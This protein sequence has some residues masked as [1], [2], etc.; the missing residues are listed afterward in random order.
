[1]MLEL[2]GRGGRGW[3]SCPRGLTELVPLILQSLGA[4]SPSA[5]VR[6]IRVSGEQ[7]HGLGEAWVR[8]ELTEWGNSRPEV[9]TP[10]LSRSCPRNAQTQ[11]RT[12]HTSVDTHL[13]ARRSD[14]MRHLRGCRQNPRGQVPPLLPCG[15]LSICSYAYGILQ[16]T[17][18][19]EALCAERNRQDAQTLDCVYHNINPILQQKVLS[20]M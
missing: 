18:A 11:G 20:S 13:L 5:Q 14:G 3:G 7:N 19:G 16:R 8:T 17:E 2:Y 4:R 15:Y 9:I 1:M 6:Y 12:S 10:D